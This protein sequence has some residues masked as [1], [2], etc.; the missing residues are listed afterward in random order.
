M[1][2]EYR[3]HAFRKLI[4]GTALLAAVLG[5]EPA[6]AQTSAQFEATVSQLL[7]EWDGE[8]L[9]R[10][11]YVLNR[12]AAVF[13]ATAPKFENRAPEESAT[14]IEIAGEFL[15]RAVG[16]EIRL[17]TPR[18]EA[19]VA[20]PNGVARIAV[21]YAEHMEASMARSGAY[22]DEFARSDIAVCSGILETLRVG[23]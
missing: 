17:G 22:L 8:D 3:M 21:L 16:V 6:A 5:H 10:F 2:L 12:C 4:A 7:E 13:S 18:D 14:F 9:S 20:I 19:M 11:R 1:D 15:G 23:E